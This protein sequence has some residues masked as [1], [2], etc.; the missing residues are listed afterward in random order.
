MP[1]EVGAGKSSEG[2]NA[3]HGPGLIAKPGERCIRQVR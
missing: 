3:V 1:V 2:A